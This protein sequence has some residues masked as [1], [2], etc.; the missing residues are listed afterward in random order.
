MRKRKRPEKKL[1]LR[2]QKVDPFLAYYDR[3]NNCE[4]CELCQN[5]KNVV[6]LK[7]RVPATVLFVGEGPGESEDSEGI[8][9]HGE[10]GKLLESTIMRVTVELVFVPRFAFT[11][12]VGCR[13]TDDSGKNTAPRAEHAKACA[14]RLQEIVNLVEPKVVVAVGNIA[15][16]YVTYIRLPDEAQLLKT[17]HPSAILR[18]ESGPGLQRLENTITAAFKEAKR[19]EEI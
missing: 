4:R 5:R 10:A 14:P 12:I 13:S 3:W 16:H 15:Q 8:P 6:H 9:F 7:G 1:F 2:P 11:N 17:I 19:V 18:N